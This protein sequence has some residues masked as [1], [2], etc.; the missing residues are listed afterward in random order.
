MDPA[1]TSERINTSEGVLLRARRQFDIE[2]SYYCLECAYLE[3]EVPDDVHDIQHITFTTLSHDQG[4]LGRFSSQLLMVRRAHPS[5]VERLLHWNDVANDQFQRR[6]TTW[7]VQP[8]SDV[9]TTWLRTLQPRDIIQIIP[10]ALFQGWVNFVKEAE[11]EVLGRQRAEVFSPLEGPN[12][13]PHGIYESIK[14]ATNDIRLLSI[15]PGSQEEPMS[16]FLSKASLADMEQSSFEALSYCWGDLSNRAPIKLK[17]ANDISESPQAIKNY[18]F[19]ITENLFAAL[20]ALRSATGNPRVIWVDAICINQVHPEERNRQVALMRTIYSKATQVIVWL[21]ETS[22]FADTAFGQFRWFSDALEKD[23]RAFM[24]ELSPNKP[25]GVE[26]HSAWTHIHSGMFFTMPWFGRAWV[27]QE[28]F[29]AQSASVQWGSHTIPWSTLL[30]VNDCLTKSKAKHGEIGHMTMPYVLSNLFKP[31]GS[32]GM[33]SFTKEH[34][35][36]TLDIIVGGIDLGCSDPR[37][38]IFSLVHLGKDTD[39]LPIDIRPDYKKPCIDVFV[40]FTRYW[41]TKNKSL[42]IL[43]AIHADFGRTWQRM[44]WSSPKDLGQTRPSWSLWYTGNSSWAHTSLGLSKTCR[45]Q[46]SGSAA[47]EIE[48]PDSR[49]LYL[50]G[51]RLGTIVEIDAYPYLGRTAR[52]EMEEVFVSLFDPLGESQTWTPSAT[53][54]APPKEESRHNTIRWHATTHYRHLRAGNFGFPCTSKC[55]FTADGL[56]SQKRVG[57]CPYSAQ[58]G[59]IV[60]VL[61]GGQVPFILRKRDEKGDFDS[62]EQYVLVGEA[63]CEEY[64][65][66]KALEDV[67]NGRLKKEVFKLV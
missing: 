5:G 60:V 36:D 17:V 55:F 25:H 64:M 6:R 43:S 3:L 51:I 29:N 52:P 31:D 32:G 1:I 48:A 9:Q 40:D 23:E 20:K 59:D 15:E 45:Y 58:R 35:L 12:L 61:Y 37:D 10:R 66:G 24:T 46:A 8:G 62:T 63:Y 34:T 65:H 11:I 47:L 19:E 53:T 56:D 33:F 42:R 39:E 28:V 26:Y 44:T 14:L 67:E 50:A 41:I 57:L 21:G 22:T 38:K 7:A 18:D 4:M 27:V 13:K 54:Q 30:R 16:L 2:V 49:S